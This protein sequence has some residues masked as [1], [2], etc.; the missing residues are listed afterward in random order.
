MI[1]FNINIKLI[2]FTIV[3]FG[4]V[5]YNKSIEKERMIMSYK[6]ISKCPICSSK[7]KV[8]KLRCTKCGTVIENDF[9]FSKF[10][11]LEEEHLNFMEVF[12]KCRGNIKDV[13]KELG[14]SYPTVR[15]KL[16]DVVAALGYTQVKKATIASNEI[17][18]LLE[19]GEI[20]PEQAVEMLK[21]N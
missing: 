16:D 6:V 21:N 17:L 20:S 2:N 5:Y 13:E 10:E 19:K 4:N 1:I 3:L 12:L 7:L 9:E 15:A 14:I 11:Y 18:D 8:M